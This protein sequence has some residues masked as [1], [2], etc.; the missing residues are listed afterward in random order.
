MASSTLP[1]RFREGATRRCI[2]CRE[3]KLF[4][5]YHYPPSLHGQPRAQCIPC[6]RE[7]DKERRDANRALRATQRRARYLKNTYGLNLADFD[8]KAAEQDGKCA[9]CGHAESVKARGAVLPLAVHMPAPAG[10]W[11]LWCFRCQHAK[12][13][14]RMSG[15][16]R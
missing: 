4:S 12:H 11:E 5:E 9:Q 13:Y 2:R 6:T 15:G 8:A 14:Q 10:A 7:V 16:A 1:Y 3:R